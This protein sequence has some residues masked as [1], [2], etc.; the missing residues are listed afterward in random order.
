VSAPPLR[1]RLRVRW[2]RL[3]CGILGWHRPGPATRMYLDAPRL[4]AVCRRCGYRG[5]LDSQGDLR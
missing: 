2:V 3:L 4:H 5:L 1:V